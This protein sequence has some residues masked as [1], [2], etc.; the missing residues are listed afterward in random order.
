M[1][2]YVVERTRRWTWPLRLE[3]V[4]SRVL[5]VYQQM[6]L[7]EWRVTNSDPAAGILEEKRVGEV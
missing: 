1:C 6:G 7:E 3:G 5:R 4:E 2:V